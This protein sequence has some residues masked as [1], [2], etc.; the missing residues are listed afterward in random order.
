MTDPDRRPGE[1]WEDY[2]RRVNS[3]ENLPTWEELRARAAALTDDEIAGIDATVGI[4]RY[5]RRSA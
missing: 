2:C 4:P 3:A 5:E 1:S